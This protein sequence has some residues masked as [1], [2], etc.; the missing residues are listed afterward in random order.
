MIISETPKKGDAG[1]I[2]ED[3]KVISSGEMSPVSDPLPVQP[4]SAKPTAAAGKTAEAAE[5]PGRV[6]RAG[7]KRG[8]ESQAVYLPD[9]PR[10]KRSGVEPRNDIPVGTSANWEH[11]FSR[12]DGRRIT[13][14]DSASD[15]EVARALVQG[16]LLPADEHSIR[17]MP[18][19]KL[20][21]LN[22]SFQIRVCFLF[23]LFSISFA[24]ICCFLCHISDLTFL[25]L[26]GN[27]VSG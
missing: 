27:P 17:S 18:S 21:T 23:F 7:Q 3:P 20:C 9:M 10:R 22:N 6:T 25:L 19:G 16:V 24:V 26:A 2:A 8:L 1:A 13:E 11:L 4:L 5:A 15:G 12:A 14:A